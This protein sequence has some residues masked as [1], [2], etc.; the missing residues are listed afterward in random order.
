MDT[1]VGGVGGVVCIVGECCGVGG[2]GMV[3]TSINYMHYT[4]IQGYKLPLQC[5]RMSKW[6]E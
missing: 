4:H 5:E 1:G 2:E 6:V 3:S